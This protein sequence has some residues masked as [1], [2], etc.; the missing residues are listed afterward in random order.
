MP[1]SAADYARQSDPECNAHFRRRW[2]ETAWPMDH[3]PARICGQ[4]VLPIDAMVQH[5]ADRSR[6]VLAGRSLEAR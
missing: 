5:S 1:K 3:S 6:H 2:I 4:R